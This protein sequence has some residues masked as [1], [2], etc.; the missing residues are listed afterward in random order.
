M[1]LSPL[2]LHDKYGLKSVINASGK[3]T[4]LGVATSETA[5]CQHVDYGLSHLFVM[6]ELVEKTGRFIADLV[7]AESA[8]VV[9][10]TSA[11]IA[12]S[13]AGLIV[14]DDA[15]LLVTLHEQIASGRLQTPREI[16]VPKGHQVDYGV[17]VGT[18]VALGGGVVVEA[19]YANKCSAAHIE[20]KITANT[21]AI[22]YVKSHHC[23][24]KSML[25]VSAAV[26][27]AKKHG[28][29]LIVDASAEEDLRCYYEM[30]ADIVLYSG[31][32]AIEGPS[33]GLVIGKTQYVE[34]IKKQA[35]GMGRAM[36]VGKETILGLTHAI[37]RYLQKTPETGLDMIEKM[38][39]FVA[40]IN[41]TQGLAAKTVWDSAGRDIAR[42]EIQF[43]ESI[44]KINPVLLVEQ[45][46]TG[47]PAIYFREP[48]LN[49][50]KV[51]VDV[52]QV[53]A[54]QLTQ[55]YEALRNALPVL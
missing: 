8:T 5:V 54:A 2:S 33:S 48:Q 22:L 20:A 3:M 7:G 31:A 14:K 41:A 11:G 18:M 29:P 34:W 25:N 49:A 42:T 10:S 46:K 36:K 24:Q 26:A 55:I 50:G 6:Q 21:L 16:I 15:D 27:V 28:L 37:E 9:A 40:A 38:R 12:L 23:V 1:T 44:L 13:V 19:G 52:R 32:K 35:Y 43:D 53:T 51:E 45:L 47:N 17:P 39:P 4:I 30:G